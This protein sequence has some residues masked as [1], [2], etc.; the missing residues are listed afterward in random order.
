MQGH[1][2]AF[3]ADLVEAAS[4][5]FLTLVATAGGLAPA[6]AHAATDAVCLA[7]GALIGLNGIQTHLTVTSDHS[8]RT[9]NATL[10]IIPR[11]AGVSSS[12]RV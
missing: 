12:S 2:A 5:G 7:L 10:V 3:E 1:L 4:T 6:G 8:T 11:T 9:R